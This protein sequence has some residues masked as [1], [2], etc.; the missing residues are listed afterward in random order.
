MMI[1]TAVSEANISMIIKRGLLGRAVSN[2]EIALQERG[3]LI[4]ESPPKTTLQL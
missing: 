1:S 2:L 4:S 3:G